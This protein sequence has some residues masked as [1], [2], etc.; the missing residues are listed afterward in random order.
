MARTRGRLQPY[1]E[2]RGDGEYAWRVR[3]PLPPDESGVIKWPSASGFATDSDAI[4]HGW[5]QMV[6]I[7]RGVWVDP[8][9]SGVSFG[10]IAR[11]WMAENP[12]SPK[13]DE[14]RRYL[15]RKHILP[16]WGAEPIAD[17]KWYL[18]KTWANNLPVPEVT[19]N[20]CVTFMSTIL[21]AAVDAGM[22][23]ANPLLGRRRGTG[24]KTP[25][26]LPP[27]PII[28]PQPEQVAAIAARMGTT[29]GLMEI[30]QAWMG[31]RLGEMLAIH[32]ARSFATRT[33]LVGGRPWTRR[34]L[35]IPKDRGELEEVEILRTGDDGQ[36]VREYVLQLGSPKNDSSVREVDI[37]PFLDV[38]LTAHLATWPHEYVFATD[39]GT[40]RYR[41]NFDQRI[42]RAAG[43]WP[44]SERRRGTAGRAAT[45]PILPGLSSHGNRHGQA[46][47]MEELNLS[48]VLVAYILGHTVPGM[49]GVYRHP[50]PAMR[51]ARADA[52]EALWNRRGVHDVYY[53]GA[54]SF[55]VLPKLV[56][57]L[58]VASG[59]VVAEDA[60]WEMIST[61]SPFLSHTA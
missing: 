7:R 38:L 60:Q 42:K 33:D 9:K 39:A 54:A 21:T 57:G 36:Q 35:V 17:V 48:N 23:G 1:A 25:V 5:E 37:P 55:K 61:S 29:E 46:T 12:K 51:K 24:V 20:R 18:V 13:T 30:F 10:E 41:S 34:V 53:A 40:F 28:W 32:R 19:V 4:A 26:N 59:P 22:L 8:R 27:K 16:R 47:W 45:G 31:P 58:S 11:A 52:L 14:G 49:A 50:T 6:D 15:L 56:S 44:A 43:G 2:K 3:W